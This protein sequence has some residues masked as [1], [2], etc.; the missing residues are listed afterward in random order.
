MFYWDFAWSWVPAAAFNFD[1]VFI[2]PPF[3]HFRNTLRVCASLGLG[4][5]DSGHP[6]RSLPSNSRSSSCFLTSL[7]GS[8]CS[9]QRWKRLCFDTWTKKAPSFFLDSVPKYPPT[10]CQ[11]I[12]FA[13][14]TLKSW[15]TLAA[16]C[17]VGFGSL[18]AA[19][20]PPTGR[21]DRRHI[22]GLLSYLRKIYFKIWIYFVCLVDWMKTSSCLKR[23]Y[24]T[25]SLDFG[26]SGSVSYSNCSAKDICLKL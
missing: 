18:F 5:W 24:S 17:F 13:I 3:E 19:F 25:F 22:G 7:A 23:E 14:A 8:R 26:A 15:A 4:W 2:L 10:R 20:K 16:I 11:I 1:F 21:G 9:D 6:S 12:S